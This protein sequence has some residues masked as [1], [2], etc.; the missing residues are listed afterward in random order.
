MV[1][2]VLSKMLEKKKKK[3]EKKTTPLVGLEPT[4]FELEVQCASP[5]RHRGWLRLAPENL[6]LYFNIPFI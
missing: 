2:Y 4:T 3:K 1:E 6:N 5:L